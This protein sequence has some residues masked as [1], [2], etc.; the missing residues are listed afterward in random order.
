MSKLDK[1]FPRVP[2]TQVDLDLLEKKA[3]KG[4]ISKAQFLRNAVVFTEIKEVDKTFQKRQ[5]FL[6]S[7][8]SNNINQI[9]HHCNIY[10]KVDKKVL[11]LLEANLNFVKELIKVET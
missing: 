6:L 1:Q 4:N 7:N 11:E 5:L 9:A 10:K 8:I 2:C 3:K